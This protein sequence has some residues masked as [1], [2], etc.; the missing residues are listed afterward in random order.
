MTS[1]VVG[2]ESTTAAE[3]ALDR[4]L[5]EGRRTGQPVRAVR[6]WQTP[7]WVGAGMGQAYD[8]DVFAAQV[9]SAEA[10]RIEGQEVIDKA[11]TR[12]PDGPAV[13]V[14]LEVVEGTAGHVLVT[15]ADKA[16]LLVVGSRGH[17]ILGGA[18]FGTTTSYVLHHCSTP[19]MVVPHEG[20]PAGAF[21]S[22]VVGLDGSAASRSALRWAHRAAKDHQCPLVVAH[23]WALATVPRDEHVFFDADAETFAMKVR[24]WLHDEAAEV[25]GA[26]D[27]HTIALHGS[28]SRMLLSAVGPD[29]LLVL[30][31]RGEGGFAGLHLGSVSSQCARHSAGVVTVVRAGEERLADVR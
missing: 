17:G 23:V 29:D 22:V 25:V 21:H 1:I 8:Y 18:L 20:T 24:A 31:S 27:V 6:A 7:V 11:L 14:E 10:A 13:S 28:P 3:R 19:V 9:S 4:A 30:G 12:L 5:L 16:D 26:D 15:A 2:V